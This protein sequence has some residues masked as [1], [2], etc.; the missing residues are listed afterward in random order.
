VNTSCIRRHHLLL[1]I[2]YKA[3]LHRTG[4]VSQ[5]FQSGEIRH[6]LDF[7]SRQRIHALIIRLL[8]ELHFFLGFSDSSVFKGSFSP[9]EEKKNWDEIGDTLLY[10]MIA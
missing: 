2:L 7:R 3:F 8:V 10:M 4:E 6:T 1:C 5:G 9:Q